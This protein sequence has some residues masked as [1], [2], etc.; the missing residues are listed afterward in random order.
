MFGEYQHGEECL[1]FLG[2]SL[3][4]SSLSSYALSTLRQGDRYQHLLGLAQEHQKSSSTGIE[5]GR[6]CGVSLPILAPWADRGGGH[7]RIAKVVNTYFMNFKPLNRWSYWLRFIFLPRQREV[8]VFKE[9]DL[10]IG[11]VHHDLFSRGGFWAK[12]TPFFDQKKVNR[13]GW[14]PLRP[15]P[16]LQTMISA[17]RSFEGNPTPHFGTK[18]VSLRKPF[19]NKNAIFDFVLNI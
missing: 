10:D 6:R 7:C 15:S 16:P 14:Y 11:K 1:P 17:N 2:V 8:V 12:N 13:L 18:S 9:R 3:P 19:R 5:H 4:L